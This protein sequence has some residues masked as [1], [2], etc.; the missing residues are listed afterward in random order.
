MTEKQKRGFALLSPERRKIVAQMGGVSCPPEKRAFS[1]NKKLAS[2]AGK[3]GGKN[4]RR[5]KEPVNA[6]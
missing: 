5:K 4:G 2:E 1:T 3:K 6:P